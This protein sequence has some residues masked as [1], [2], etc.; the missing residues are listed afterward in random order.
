MLGIS[1]AW[2]GT[3]MPKFGPKKLAIIGGL[4]YASGYFISSVALAQHSLLLL[5]LGFG[6]VGGI[7]LLQPDRHG[8]EGN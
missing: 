3:V 2:G 6:I 7:G 8:G 5:Y 4:L 1:A